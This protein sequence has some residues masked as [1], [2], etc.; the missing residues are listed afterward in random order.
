MVHGFLVD[1]DVKSVKVADVPDLMKKGYTLLDVR[2][3]KD[4][5]IAHAK[6]AINVPL[7]RPVTRE[8]TWSQV[9][10]VV[11]FFMAM[12]PTGS[13]FTCCSV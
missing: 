12:T 5:K 11:S 1:N 10:K 6:G 3:E 13:F 2:L 8:N 4:F 9:K 7:F